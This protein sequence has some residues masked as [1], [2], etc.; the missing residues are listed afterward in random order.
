MSI[1]LKTY[2]LND[3]LPLNGYA[4]SFIRYKRLLKVHLF[5]GFYKNIAKFIYVDEKKLLWY[6]YHYGDANQKLIDLI[7]NEAL[8]IVTDF[9]GNVTHTIIIVVHF[10]FD[11]DGWKVHVSKWHSIT[12]HINCFVEIY[13]IA[14]IC[15]C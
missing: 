4:Y 6:C 2:I 9:I 8:S 1:N 7:K 14:H 11:V 12:Q 13:Q 3:R 10:S 5:C 15:K